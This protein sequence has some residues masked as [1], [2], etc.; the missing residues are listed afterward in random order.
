MVYLLVRFVGLIAAGGLV[1]LMS[2]CVQRVY[3]THEPDKPALAAH[4]TVAVLPFYVRLERPWVEEFAAAHAVTPAELRQRQAAECRALA[5]AL[6]TELLARLQRQ[7]PGYTVQ[8]QPVA[9]TNQRLERAGIPF[10]S[11]NYRSTEELQ[12]ILQVDAVLM[13]QTKLVQS[14]P[15]ALAL[16]MRLDMP[17]VDT[18]PSETTSHLLLYDGRTGRRV[19]QFDHQLTG[20]GS[21]AAPSLAKDLMRTAG[22]TFPYQR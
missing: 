1:G 19:W 11:L 7:R 13:G 4:R 9:E 12:R 20:K 16:M 5:Y 15:A 21:L 14:L 6:Q 22:P 17:E 2:G 8:F 3:S 10:D 18:P